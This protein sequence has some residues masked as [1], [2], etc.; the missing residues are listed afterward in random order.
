M[1]TP[2]F[3]FVVGKRVA[4]GK[5]SNANIDK[6]AKENKKEKRCGRTSAFQAMSVRALKN[7]IL[8]HS[9]NTYIHRLFYHYLGIKAHAI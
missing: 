6:D 4:A 9:Q 2:Q 1:H 5:K 3:A 7:D 8:I